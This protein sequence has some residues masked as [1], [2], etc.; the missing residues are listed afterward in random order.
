MRRIEVGDV[1]WGGFTAERFVIYAATDSEARSIWEDFQN[2]IESEGKHVRVTYGAAFEPEIQRFGVVALPVVFHAAAKYTAWTLLLQGARPSRSQVK[3][4][5]APFV[6]D[7]EQEVA[8][9]CMRAEVAYE[10]ANAPRTFEEAVARLLERLSEEK[11]DDLASS[12][13]PLT[14][15]D[16]NPLLRD[17]LHSVWFHDNP[18]LVWSCGGSV[19]EGLPR[20]VAE[21]RRRLLE[22]RP[23]QD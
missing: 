7:V 3:L 19:D 14:W 11:R 21:A 18:G 22:E 2:I 12:Y 6:S 20:I 5:L 8:W 4:W 23:P 13:G 16:E 15:L 1:R 17:R 9:E 10:R